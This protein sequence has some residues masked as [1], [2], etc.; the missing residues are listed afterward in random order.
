MVLSLALLL[1][2]VAAQAEAAHHQWEGCSDEEHS[3]GGC[4]I[5]ALA[6]QTALTTAPQ[7]REI[8]ITIAGEAALL[9]VPIRVQLVWLSPFGPRSPPCPA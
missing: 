5:C 2:F 6:H 7:P 8:V 3:P 4:V 9:P 1:A